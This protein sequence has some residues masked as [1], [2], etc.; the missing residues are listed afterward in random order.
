MVHEVPHSNRTEWAVR[1]INNGA[2]GV[3]GDK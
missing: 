1:L 3:K 2:T